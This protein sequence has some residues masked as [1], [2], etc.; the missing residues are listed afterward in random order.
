MPTYARKD[1]RIYRRLKFGKTMDLIMLDQRQ[2]RDDQPCDDAVVPGCAELPEPRDLLGRK[3][4]DWAKQ[5][6]SSSKAA[7]KVVGNEVMMM[8]A[9]VLGGSYYTFDSWQGYQT[10]REELLDHIKDKGVDDVV[11]VT[12]D[13]HTFI[14]GD[15]RTQAAR[16]RRSRWSSWAARSRPRASARR[17]STAGGGV[18]IPGNDANPNTPQALIDALRG[19]N[20][21]VDQADFDHHGYGLVEGQP[22]GLRRH[23]QAR[24]DDQGED[25]RDRA[26]RRLPL[27]R[28]ARA[29]VDQGRQRA[30]RLTRRAALHERPEAAGLRLRTRPP[31]HG[32]RGRRRRSPG[33]GSPGR[34][35]RRASPRRR[36]G[37]RGRRRRAPRRGR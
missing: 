24:L 11:F 36:P 1:D 10:E 33:P 6:L 18:T 34:W 16:A 9:K 22:Q 19:I 20:P 2:Y 4:M 8:P 13:I 30:G 32:P 31:R 15:V 7:W 35:S 37:A 12:G 21:W 26:D 23:A 3:Q 14:A 25:D 29:E 17:T 27:P 5:Q 28:R